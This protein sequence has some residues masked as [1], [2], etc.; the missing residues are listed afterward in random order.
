MTLIVERWLIGMALLVGL[1]GFGFY[2]G[3]HHANEKW[4]AREDAAKAAALDD[5]KSQVE[6]ISALSSQLA[7]AQANTKVVYKTITNE[8]S[9]VI[10]KPIYSQCVLDSGGYRLWNDSNTRKNST[11]PIAGQSNAGLPGATPTPETG[12]NGAD[13]AKPR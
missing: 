2:K 5:Y 1:F 7:M 8:V 11:P 10:E 12:N 4:Q 9:H 3:N 6:R 13:V